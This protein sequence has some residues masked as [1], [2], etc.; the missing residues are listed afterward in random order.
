MKGVEKLP[1]QRDHDL[2]RGGQRRPRGHPGLQLQLAHRDQPGGPIQR[3]LEE[4]VG[5]ARDIG[6]DAPFSQSIQVGELERELVWRVEHVE[7]AAEGGERHLEEHLSFL[8]EGMPAG[9]RPGECGNGQRDI[10]YHHEAA[11]KE[12]PCPPEFSLIRTLRSASR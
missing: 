7:R 2:A 10:S 4:I 3:R 11:S 5:V 1:V 8:I 9:S 6:L 12:A